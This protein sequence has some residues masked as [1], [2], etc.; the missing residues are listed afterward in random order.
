MAQD[1]Q[2]TNAAKPAP[3]VAHDRIHITRYIIAYM[4]NTPLNDI[5]HLFRQLYR[6]K[7]K[8]TNYIC[9][10]FGCTP[11]DARE[12]F[13]ESCIA[14][15]QN[16][17]NGRLTKLTVASSTY[18]MSIGIHKMM[19]KQK[20]PW[21]EVPISEGNFEQLERYLQ[22]ENETDEQLTEKLELA[23]SLME[24]VASSHCRDIL[25]GYYWENLNMEELAARL[26]KKNADVVKAQ[27]SQC[28]QKL[29]NHIKNV[30]RKEELI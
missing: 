29:K 30:F 17:K 9:N 26:N 22:A 16:I 27:K 6:E 13:Q 14:M 25:W 3:P 8:F 5:D 2:A 18:L 1:A 15:F 19:D 10:K 23:N 21:T 4:N 12:L 24:Q 28:I 11:E 20:R 7:E